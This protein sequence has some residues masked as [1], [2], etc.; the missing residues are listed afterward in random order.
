M[1]TYTVSYLVNGIWKESEQVTATSR[2]RVLAGF[3]EISPDHYSHGFDHKGKPQPV[4]K[5]HG[6]LRVRLAS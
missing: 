1:N 6:C 5:Y 4:G 3:R 2:R